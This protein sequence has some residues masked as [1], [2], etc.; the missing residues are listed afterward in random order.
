MTAFSIVEEDSSFL[1]GPHLEK[2]AV[3]IQASGSVHAVQKP[4]LTLADLFLWFTYTPVEIY[5][6]DCLCIVTTKVGLETLLLCVHISLLF[7]CSC[8]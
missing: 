6:M 8:N 2:Q 7:F 1:W 5:R 4:F 3:Q